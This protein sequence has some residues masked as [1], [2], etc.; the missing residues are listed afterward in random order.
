MDVGQEVQSNYEE[1]ADV[2]SN[3]HKMMKCLMRAFVFHLILQNVF[4]KNAFITARHLHI[5]KINYWYI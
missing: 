4:P 5:K 2:Q 1:E 3:E